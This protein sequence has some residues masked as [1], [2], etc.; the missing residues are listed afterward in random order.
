MMTSRAAC[1]KLESILHVDP[2]PLYR[3]YENRYVYFTEEGRFFL[4]DTDILDGKCPLHENATCL[5]LLHC[6]KLIPRQLTTPPLAHVNTIGWTSAPLRATH[7][8]VRTA[9]QWRVRLHTTYLPSNNLHILCLFSKLGDWPAGIFLCDNTNVISCKALSNES[10]D[11]TPWSFPVFPSVGSIHVMYGVYEDKSCYISDHFLYTLLDMSIPLKHLEKP[12]NSLYTPKKE[13]KWLCYR[14]KGL[15]IYWMQFVSSA[16]P[17]DSDTHVFY[18]KW[19]VDNKEFQAQVL[20]SLFN[21]PNFKR[22]TTLRWQD[23]IV[24][25]HNPKQKI[26]L[27]DGE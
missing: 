25:A 11:I 19:A 24:T 23:A 16:L 6:A 26:Y 5:D 14:Y 9:L 13:D 12:C 10:L 22:L 15:S 27:T 7:S 1:C 3:V 18:Y 4:T 20:S 17:Y 8:F 21:T 2:P